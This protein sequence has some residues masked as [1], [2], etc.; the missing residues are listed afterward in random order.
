MRTV[1][2]TLATIAM[3]TAP[4]YS[5]SQGNTVKRSGSEQQQSAEPQ[6]KSAAQSEKAYKAAQT[7]DTAYD[8]WRSI[9]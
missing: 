1:V 6:K 3:L 9:R 4:A 2:I 8:P 5:Q 7:P